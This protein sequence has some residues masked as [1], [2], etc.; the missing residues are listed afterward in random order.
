[1]A[2]D[3]KRIEAELAL[4]LIPC[5]EM[6]RIAWD[7]L[8]AGMDGRAIRRLAA[9][10]NPTFFQVQDVLPGAC[11]E[12]QLKKLSPGAAAL[13]IAALWA[14]DILIDDQDPQQHCA[15]FSQLWINSGYPHE[16]ASIGN[17]DDDIWVAQSCGQSDREIRQWVTDRLREI[18]RCAAHH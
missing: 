17:L 8:E 4:D 11:E 9:L 15:K 1:M 7:A 3:R 18:I 2:F 13:R 5:S 6:P 12:M 16:I 14:N 10:E